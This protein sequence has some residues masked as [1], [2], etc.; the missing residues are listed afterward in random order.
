MN[1][2]CEY[3]NQ[4]EKDNDQ[5]L[6]D[7]ADS[8]DSNDNADLSLNDSIHTNGDNVQLDSIFGTINDKLEPNDA[9]WTEFGIWLTQWLLREENHGHYLY[10]AYKNLIKQR[11]IK[12]FYANEEKKQQPN[13]E[14]EKKQYSQYAPYKN[15]LHFLLHLLYRSQ[16]SSAVSRG[17]LDKF[18]CILKTMKSFG[19]LA[20]D[21]YDEIPR[22]AKE[23]TD[24]D[25]AVPQLE[26][27]IK[28]LW[29]TVRKSPMKY[30]QTKQ[31]NEIDQIKSTRKKFIRKFSN[32]QIL[33]QNDEKEDWI[34]EPRMYEFDELCYD[35]YY[36]IQKRLYYF[37]LAENIARN[38]LINTWYKELD[39]NFIEY[40]ENELP[41]IYKPITKFTETE[42]VR[43][44]QIYE[45]QFIFELPN[46]TTFYKKCLI[47]IES[48]KDEVMYWVK[49]IKYREKGHYLYTLMKLSQTT[50]SEIPIHYL[51][52][53]Y[54][55]IVHV[56]RSK[57]IWELEQ[58]QWCVT[59]CD[60]EVPFEPD[61]DNIHEWQRVYN[62]NYSTINNSFIP[63]G[64]N[65]TIE[66]PQEQH[67]LVKNKGM[68]LFIKWSYDGT[69]VNLNQKS[70]NNS[71][72]TVA[73]HSLGKTDN[74]IWRM[75]CT[76]DGIPQRYCIHLLVE[77]VKKLQKGF[78]VWTISDDGFG[79]QQRKC[80]GTLAQITLDGKDRYKAQ[81]SVG[82][83]SRNKIDGRTFINAKENGMKYPPKPHYY[84][85]DQNVSLS[86]FGIQIP[87]K[88]KDYLHTITHEKLNQRLKGHFGGKPWTR[89]PT[90]KMT[91]GCAV[92]SSPYK[93]WNDFQGNTFNWN[94]LRLG[95]A[96][97]YHTSS[98]GMITKLFNYQS[99]RFHHQYLMRS[100]ECLRDHIYSNNDCLK[101]KR[102]SA[103]KSL[104][105]EHNM[106]Q[107]YCKWFYIIITLPWLLQWNEGIGDL[108]QLIRLV[109][110]VVLCNTRYEL[111]KINQIAQRLF[112][113]LSEKYKKIT[114]TPKFRIIKETWG[115][116]LPLFGTVD[117]L[118]GLTT[119]RAHQIP[120]KKIKFRSNNSQ[121][122]LQDVI[123]FLAV[124]EG[125]Q[126]ILNGGHYGTNLQDALGK[127]ARELKDPDDDQKIHPL[128]KE[129][130]FDKQIFD[131]ENDLK[132]DEEIQNM[133]DLIDEDEEKEIEL[134]NNDDDDDNNDDDDDDDDDDNN[135]EAQFYAN[136]ISERKHIF[137]INKSHKKFSHCFWNYWIYG[138]VLRERWIQL[139][140]Y[141]AQNV[142]HLNTDDL[143]VNY[144]KNNIEVEKYGGIVIIDRKKSN[145]ISFNYS[146]NDPWNYWVKI[147]DD[148]DNKI[149][150]LNIKYI[151]KFSTND[152][153]SNNAYL[154]FGDC[155]LVQRAQFY[156]DYV[157][158]DGYGNFL[159][160]FDIN[161]K[162]TKKWFKVSRKTILETVV[163]MHQH[164]P[165]PP[166]VNYQTD[167]IDEMKPFYDQIKQKKQHTASAIPCGP[168]LK[169]CSH[170][171]INCVY[172]SCQ[173]INKYTMKWYCN[174]NTT[175]HQGNS[176]FLIWDAK[177]AWLPGIWFD[178]DEKKYTHYIQ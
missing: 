141:L 3:W 146:K 88:W 176:T 10:K 75:S 178:I 32:F 174:T 7:N 50:I 18:I 133:E 121:E 129:W 64:I 137:V 131:Y 105:Q 108:M 56:L 90:P 20:E 21:K 77:Q 144:C 173:N 117:M 111:A 125:I 107:M 163:V 99:K 157:D 142:C 118:E 72:F 86:Q 55:L 11:K 29:M 39:T 113:H 136:K 154:A 52:P 116:D 110:R 135:D 166:N 122:D 95:I 76:P 102:L 68:F 6:N 63:N 106:C 46:G 124:R 61:C 30:P 79:F 23:I 109:G 9:T 4:E 150:V 53:H 66:P 38:S 69:L 156:D 2:N 82:A 96:E 92:A 177:N 168:I 80:A 149:K 24:Y 35:D 128:L 54:Y 94:F 43:M 103:F 33:P 152:L 74:N 165:H 12:Y 112:E 15:G 126:Y 153:N 37:D 98:F 143:D 167:Y 19:L 162:L 161:S 89:F 148:E 48:K 73:N 97:F 119:E 62:F 138:D 127:L 155:Y 84:Q 130:I 158:T 93:I 171:E 34:S 22:N 132:N 172:D 100:Y 36:K 44:H 40:K 13:E 101:H 170:G 71:I 51:Q 8:N 120:K 160:S 27:H 139:Q 5:C 17:L 151:F 83:S 175:Y 123:R 59:E 147:K 14:E 115:L 104:N 57:Y 91:K 28:H 164:V 87:H 169:C 45:S 25:E 145:K 16:S 134:K 70:V 140:K 114:N 1:W 31:N 58:N 159:D 49:A 81:Y 41:S 78:I 26:I 60:L 42:F 65:V 85:E 67:E 47:T